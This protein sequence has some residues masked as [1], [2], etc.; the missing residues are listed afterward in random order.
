MKCITLPP[1][2]RLVS[3]DERK[4]LVARQLRAVMLAPA[5][6]LLLDTRQERQPKIPRQR[7]A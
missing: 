5:G 1:R 2:V 4:A 6:K 7:S 3:D